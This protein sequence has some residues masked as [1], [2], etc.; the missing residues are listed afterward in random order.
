MTADVAADMMVSPLPQAVVEAKRFLARGI[1][2]AKGQTF[3]AAIAQFT[4]AIKAA[5]AI[6][7]NTPRPNPLKA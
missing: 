5:F 4:A 2:L 7:Q 1:E 3:E 6:L